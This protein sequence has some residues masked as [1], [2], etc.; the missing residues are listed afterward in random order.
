MK[1]YEIVARGEDCVTKRKIIE[2]NNYNEALDIAWETFP[3]Y[4]SVYVNEVK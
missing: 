4:D 1:K 3:E 2:A